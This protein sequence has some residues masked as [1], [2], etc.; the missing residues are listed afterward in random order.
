L[1]TT[2][3]DEQDVMLDAIELWKRYAVTNYDEDDLDLYTA[4]VVRILDR[5][6]PVFT[7]AD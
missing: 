5:I 4:A 2:D 6:D 3:Q 7:A 1:D